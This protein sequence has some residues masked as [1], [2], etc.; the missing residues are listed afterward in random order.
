MLVFLL[1]DKKWYF[2]RNSQR[3]VGPLSLLKCING[4]VLKLSP[5]TNVSTTFFGSHIC[6]LVLHWI[7]FNRYCPF[8]L[9]EIRL[10]CPSPPPQRSR[11]PT[12]VRSEVWGPLRRWWSIQKRSSLPPSLYGTEG[13]RKMKG[14]R[15][16]MTGNRCG[17]TYFDLFTSDDTSGEQKLCIVSFVSHSFSRLLFDRSWCVTISD[18][19]TVTNVP[20]LLYDENMFR[21]RHG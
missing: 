5:R 18:F 6:L 19:G 1:C 15:V 11:S 20:T 7:S 13:R 21:R 10:S 14:Y 16:T 2:D 8:L 3:H 9:V 4:S 12:P 17:S